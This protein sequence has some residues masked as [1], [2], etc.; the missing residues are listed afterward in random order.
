MRTVRPA[1]ILPSIVLNARSQFIS[2][3]LTDIKGGG[4]GGWGFQFAD[5]AIKIFCPS[6][7]AVSRQR[8]V[9]TPVTGKA[10]WRIPAS[11]ALLRNSVAVKTL[12][13]VVPSP[14]RLET[15]FHVPSK[16][17]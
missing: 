12:P 9:F 10:C 15:C 1:L 13:A 3:L 4:G 5:V 6:P 7:F 14:T 2:W 17:K 16:S 11:K 8:S